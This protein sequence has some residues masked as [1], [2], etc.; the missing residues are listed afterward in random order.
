MNRDLELETFLFKDN[1]KDHYSITLHWIMT[2]TPNF[3]TFLFDLL[4][5][6]VQML[7]NLS[8]ITRVPQWEGRN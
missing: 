2:Y 8:G 4:E 1:D 7:V 3:P 6:S 5:D